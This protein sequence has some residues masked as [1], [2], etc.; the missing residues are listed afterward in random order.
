MQ[1]S[2]NLNPPRHP[3]K[4][5]Y[6]AIFSEWLPPT[7][8]RF[9]AVV[10]GFLFFVAIF[11]PLH[12]LADAP[13]AASLA[14]AMGVVP[15]ALA[16]WL[17]GRRAALVMWG[18]VFVAII[19]LRVVI[20]ETE[21]L[22]NPVPT[23][24]GSGLLLLVGLTVG[25]LSEQLAK[26]NILAARV[27]REQQLLESEALERVRVQETLRAQNEYLAALNDTTL[28][29]VGRLNLNELLSDILNRA[30]ELVGT[31][32]GYVF[33][34]DENA[35]E[36]VM[37][38]GVGAYQDFVGT[39]AEPGV[40][41]AGKVW[42]T[43]EAVAVDDYRNWSGRL[44]DPSRN[45]LRAVVGIPL[46]RNDKV[47]GIIG[48]AHLESD[49]RF[50]VAE[51][52]VLS[53]FA[54]LASIALDNAQ[55]YE[56]SQRELEQRR[57]FE[58]ALSYERDLLQALMDNIP[59]L[60]FFKD[61]ESRFVRSNAAHLRNLGA[62]NMAQ[63]FGKTDLD[64]HADLP[65]HTFMDDEKHILET[66]E[67]ILNKVE[68][69]PAPDGTMRYFSTSKVPWRDQDGNIIGTLGVAHNV[70]DI[71][72]A[73][74]NLKAEFAERQAA[75][76][77]LNTLV[78]NIP[79]GIFVKDA[80]DL[81]MVR[82]N[83]ANEEI[84]GI[85]SE[86]VI[87]KT[88]YDLFPAEQAEFFVA[89]D[90][91]TLAS[92]ALLDI[93][94]EPIQTSHHG[95]RYLHTK[96][97]PLYDE[98]GK[99][100]YL[101]GISE[102]ITERKRAEE[103]LREN[104]R[105]LG[106]AQEIAHIGSW[107]WDFASGR[108]EWS[109]ELY[110]ILGVKPNGTPPR[111][112]QFV[113]DLVH[114]DDKARLHDLNQMITAEELP[115]PLEFRIIARDGA[116]RYL[117]TENE[118]IYNEQGESSGVIGVV[119][120]VTER[121]HAEQQLR[122]SEER[123]RDLFE[124]A[125]DLVQSVGADGHILYVNRAWKET[126]GYND[127]NIHALRF[128][129]VV[130]PDGRH[131]YAELISRL[132][133][134]EI[135]RNITAQL[136]TRDGRK[137]W[138]EGSVSPR[139]VEG[140]VVSTRAI[141]RDVTARREFEARAAFQNA[142]L[143]AQY[144]VS[145]DGILVVG[146]DDRILSYNRRFMEM[147]NVSPEVMES[148]NAEALRDAV[149]ANL[150][151]VDGWIQRTGEIYMA[152]DKATRDEVEF[153]DGRVFE[154]HSAPINT[155]EGTYLGRVWFFHD[156]TETIRAQQDM[157]HIVESAGA[158]F[159][160]STVTVLRDPTLD[161]EGYHWETTISNF[162][163]LSRMIP[164]H[165]EPDYSDIDAWYQSWLEEDRAAMNHTSAEAFRA[166]KDGYQ[167]EFR[168][169]DANGE[170][171]WMYEDARVTKLD[172]EHYEVVGVTLEVTAQRR[173]QEALQYERYLLESLMD[174]LPH[175]IYFKDRDSRFTRINRAQAVHLGLRDPSEALGKTDFDMFSE[176]HARPAFEDE[177][178]IMQT[179]EPIVNKEELEVFPDG[180]TQ[181]S[182][183][184]KM[185][186]RT[187]QGDIIGTFGIS[188]DVT[189][190]KR[191]EEMVSRQNAY[192]NALQETSLGLMQRLDVN[193]LLQ[194]IVARAGAL[195]GTESGYVF[196]RDPDFQEMELRVGIGAYEGF[197]GRRTKMGVGLAG[198]V[199]ETNAP[200]VVDDYRTWGGRLADASR[201][202]L[203][204]VVGVPLR[205]GN[206]A[207]GVIGLA[208]LDETRKF[209]EQEVQALQRFAQLATIA[210]DNARL[211][212]TAQQE[213]Q[214]RARAEAALEK[215]LRETEL[216]NR[217]TNDAVSL[218]VDKALVAICRDLAEYFGVEQAG[219]A[220]L[221]EDRETLTVV[222]DHSPAEA[223]SVTGY[224]IPVRGN[225]STEIVFETRQ[226]AAFPD[227]QTDPRLASIHDLMKTRNTASI[228]I[229]PLF[230]RDEIIGTL[231]IDS[232]TRRE[233]SQA[234]IALVQRVALAIS[235]AL[236]NTRLYRAAQ[237][238]LA[239]RV[240]AEQEVRQRNKELEVI[241]RVSAVMTTDIGMQPALETLAREMVQ[242][243]RARNCGIALLN[244]DKQALTVVADALSEEHEEHAVGI[245]IP[246][247]NNPSTQYVL[248]HRRSLVI[249]DA[250][251]D[252][253]TAPIHERMRQRRTKCLAIIPL[254]AGGEVIGTIGLDT[255]D[256]NHI[257]SDEEMRLAETIANQMANAIEKQRLF[258]QTRERARREQ[259][260][261]EIGASMT[262]SLNLEMILKTTA[263]ELSH[264]LGASHAV[265]RVGATEAQGNGGDGQA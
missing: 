25:W 242:T 44:A 71:V 245:V 94:E 154:R 16:G 163:T 149:R 210:L 105:M 129:D 107:R 173:A 193:S 214:E 46:K 251:T 222:A 131:D 185:P 22:N 73:E 152:Q 145:P 258:D 186:L 167:Q 13:G 58:R 246:V 191:A 2:S 168:V 45:V 156:V 236:E 32:N 175:Y 122:E 11:I 61:R 42:Q 68:S 48:L 9:I 23:F 63:V 264:A 64:F 40:A 21:Y 121:R 263:R 205:S 249:P 99:P 217:V 213:L 37:R 238:E 72:V 79:L 17:F 127:M 257:F 181:W 19:I 157:R 150:K 60:I 53:R 38:V 18:A 95:L 248:E 135:V 130:H 81:R 208:Y 3:Q 161:A 227:A 133:R 36:M 146:N 119:R 239:E 89:K 138:L 219:I 69:N 189:E 109:E 155:A 228:L 166:G 110:R 259:L 162:D 170:I 206:Q 169:R 33:L 1:S 59:D 125:S 12:R 188:V 221:N 190:R 14:V 117:Y 31:K 30:G 256:P 223:P 87:D 24:I 65:A 211:Y 151:D 260:T 231:G 187:A 41:L 232:T 8:N 218:D 229:A 204:A 123:Y 132:L 183:A 261:R 165:R 178:A 262:R 230:V 198:Q 148:G 120:D 159:W 90:R 158:I 172:E 250:Q 255:T 241:A 55:L 15:I 147:W 136:L 192:L 85:K 5:W 102:D 164:L 237:Q 114:P 142:L 137:V 93:A 139:I 51:M 6:S 226:P 197:V 160:R 209:G 67:P 215:Q 216:L 184:T 243:F 234:E 240:R 201:D 235:T 195:V 27:R 265:V 253:M 179:G 134:G 66:G 182:S 91:E 101:L 50:G 202:I 104:A 111:L 28:A 98:S 118:Q 212:E 177:L 194:D 7:R 220:L 88:D 126:L 70:T 43:G 200:V 82:W 77:F 20:G 10:V 75:E 207:V 4:A 80:R 34:L 244:E 203:R 100:A 176:E 174:N 35:N 106:K 171:H 116:V 252:P 140:R 97:I 225:P 254:L 76:Q 92:G 199:W 47:N 196:L 141:F 108:V 96:K 56:S 113:Q 78:T 128:V 54:S 143:G 112:D 247:E 233:F 180:S 26:A 153:K 115:M 224:V 39:R 62:A 124:N 29:L 52:D 83:K 74:Q 103:T 144:D 49:K 57:S 84:T 86:E